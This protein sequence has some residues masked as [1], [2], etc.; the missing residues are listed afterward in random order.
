M[1][2]YKKTAQVRRQIVEAT[3]DLLYHKGYNLM[4]FSD[5][6]VASGLPRGNLNYH[7]KTK[8]EV[9]AA[10]IEHRLEQM[11][12]MLEDWDRTL[13]TPLAR[14][15]RFAQIP[16]NEI[17]NVSRYGCPM[18]SLNTELGKSQPR[19]RAISRAQ[20]DRFRE[21]LQQQFRALAPEQDADALALRLLVRAQGLA[22]VSQLYA[23]QE[24]VRREVD[25]IMDWL[26][27]V[28][29]QGARRQ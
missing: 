14:L 3:D 4:S 13:P 12:V 27:G 1:A 28:D 2:S 19:L 23:D 9:L 7:F 21:W 5:I 10:V 8:Q 20:F 17:A 11:Q 18:G 25:D 29:Q 6:A 26:Q 16:L 15:Q 24:L 22:V